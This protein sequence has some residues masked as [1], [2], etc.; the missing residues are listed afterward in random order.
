[1]NFSLNPFDIFKFFTEKKKMRKKNFSII[2]I[3][4]QKK[5]KT[6]LLFGK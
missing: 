5:Q 4:L 2:W 6:L 1:M 3:L